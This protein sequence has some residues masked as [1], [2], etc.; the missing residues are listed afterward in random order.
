LSCSSTSRSSAQEELH[1]ER[2]FLGGRR[3]FSLE[4]ASVRYST[5]TSAHAF[6]ASRRLTPRRFRPRGR[7]R[8][9]ASAC[10]S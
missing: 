4:K 6:T 10:H 2:D 5:P 9:F 3:Q 7:K 8:F 1:Q